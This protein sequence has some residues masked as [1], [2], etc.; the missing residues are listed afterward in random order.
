MDNQPKKQRSTMSIMENLI[1][2]ADV[3]FQSL[4]AL[5]WEEKKFNMD[6]CL[7]FERMSWEVLRLKNYISNMKD[8]L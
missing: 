1:D 2:Q 6:I 3:L 4:D 5:S 8:N 7:E